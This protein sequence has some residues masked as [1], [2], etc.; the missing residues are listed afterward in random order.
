MKTVSI[1]IPALDEEAY[2][3]GLLEAIRQ[4]TRS[5]LE[6]IVADAGSSDRTV[7]IA[8]QAGCRVVP[9]GRP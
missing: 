9:G 8:L 7:E 5:P 4:Q 2:L 3:P 6:V 1:V